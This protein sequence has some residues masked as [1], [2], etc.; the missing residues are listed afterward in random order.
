MKSL[1]FKILPRRVGRRDFSR[2]LELFVCLF[3]FVCFV[4]VLFLVE[5]FFAGNV[6]CVVHLRWRELWQ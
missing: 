6:C 4:F 3:V 2:L 1:D 5:F